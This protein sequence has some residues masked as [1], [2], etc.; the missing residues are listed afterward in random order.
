MTDQLDTTVLDAG[1]DLLHAD[2]L[3]SVQ[4]GRVTDGTLPP[5][6]LVHS[7]I[8]WPEVAGSNAL[9]G[10]SRT[11]WARWICHGVGD[12]RES[13]TAMA[14]RARTQLLD[15]QL[16]LPAY[17]TVAVD[18]IRQESARPVQP[19]DESLGIS[20]WTATATYKARITI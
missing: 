15:K 5:Y 8:S 17:P 16:L 13:A 18:L 19:P 10:R 1:I 12:T 3:I 6:L 20:V 9:D 11:A 2:A 7:W 4:D 14:Q